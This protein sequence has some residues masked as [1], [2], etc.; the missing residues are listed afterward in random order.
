MTLLTQINLLGIT[1]LTSKDSIGE[2]C[3]GNQGLDPLGALLVDLGE[4]NMSKSTV[5][6]STL[7]MRHKHHGLQ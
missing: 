5:L 6:A 3:Q 1:E 7:T 2:V 4:L